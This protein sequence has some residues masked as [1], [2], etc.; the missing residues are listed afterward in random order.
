M[1]AHVVTI[2]RANKCQNLSDEGI[3]RRGH[4][5]HFVF[6]L[7]KKQFNITR[8]KIYSGGSYRYLAQHNETLNFWD[9][10]GQK[11]SPPMTMMMMVMTRQSWEEE[12]T[13]DDD[14]ADETISGEISHRR[15]C[16]DPH[17]AS[18][19][20]HRSSMFESLTMRIIIKEEDEDLLFRYT[21]DEED[22]DDE[23][24]HGGNGDEDDDASDEYVPARCCQLC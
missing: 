1:F 16:H 12:V 19:L 23:D 11:T 24:V 4:I 15:C 6:F 21:D 5:Y 17:V 9:N 20:Q 22:Y 10:L 14:D 8:Q 7:P 18:P 2:F 3:L 13:T